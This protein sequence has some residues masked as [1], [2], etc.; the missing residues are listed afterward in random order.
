MLIAKI[1]NLILVFIFI[2]HTASC[3][4]MLSG[5]RTKTPK[6]LVLKVSQFGQFIKRFNYEED[7]IGNEITPSF[8]KKISRSDYIGFLFDKEDK[9]L[10]PLSKDFS[11]KYSLLKD[12]F[13]K[14]VT[15]KK[16]KISRISDSLYSVA[17]CDV[18]YKN[19]PATVK[20]VLKQESINNGIAWV[21]SDVSA[22]FL[23]DNNYSASSSK[24]IPPT[25]NE[26][27]Y[28]HLKNIFENRDSMSGYAYPGYT[29]NR[30]SIFF[31][32][33]HSG[34]IQYKNVKSLVYF[35]SDIPGWIIMVHEYNREGDNSGW[36][37]ENI[38]RTDKPMKDYMKMTIQYIN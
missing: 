2:S 33:V 37:I 36:L 14:K 4:D 13:I 22:D 34:D 32:L 28:I 17:V 15:D 6:N 18:S 25:S 31:Q 29:C 19:M 16:F 5:D 11:K 7:F 3:Q 12:E 35:I 30:L 9:R 26:V 23:Y 8:S 38:A 10:I 21:I 24:F 1:T 27:N 20:L